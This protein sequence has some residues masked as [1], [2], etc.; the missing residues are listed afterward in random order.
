MDCRAAGPSGVAVLCGL[1]ES[2]DCA[3]SSALDA[4]TRPG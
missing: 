4:S 1:F 2:M 3:E